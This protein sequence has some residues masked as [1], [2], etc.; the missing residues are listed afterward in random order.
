[1]EISDKEYSVI[2]EISNNHLPDQRTISSRTGIS[3]GLTNLIIRRLVKKGYIKAK[4]LNRK[5]IQYLLTP[6]GFAE[7]TK[8]TLLF[9]AK[10]FELLRSVKEKLKQLILQYYNMG[11]REFLIAGDDEIAE[12]CETVFAKLSEKGIEVSR[13]KGANTGNTCL[14]FKSDKSISGENVDLIK[15]LSESGVFYWEW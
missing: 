1:M 13:K 15:Y 4:Q 3:L 8:K 14:S 7:K 5:K 10:T 6:K 2:R 11:V 12:I 9:T